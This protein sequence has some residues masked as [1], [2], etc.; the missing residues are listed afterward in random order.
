ME[1]Y[2]EIQGLQQYVVK[3]N[4][5]R[6]GKLPICEE[7]HVWKAVKNEFLCQVIKKREMTKDYE[8]KEEI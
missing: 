7:Q 3:V 8:L 4:C 1:V 5:N 6:V 2:L